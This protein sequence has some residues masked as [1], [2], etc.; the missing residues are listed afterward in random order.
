MSKYFDYVPTQHVDEDE[1]EFL[2]QDDESRVQGVYNP[3]HSQITVIRYYHPPTKP[4]N[5]FLQQSWVLESRN[6]RVNRKW[7]SQDQ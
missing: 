2:D 6:S 7:L 5:L 4:K 1:D 3:M